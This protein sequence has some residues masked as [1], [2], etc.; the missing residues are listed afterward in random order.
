MCKFQKIT[1]VTFYAAKMTYVNFHT[2]VPIRL[3]TLYLYTVADLRG[4][5]WY[6]PPPTLYNVKQ[7]VIIHNTIKYI[8]FT[9]LLFFR[10]PSPKKIVE[11]STAVY[12]KYYN[13]IYNL[14]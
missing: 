8:I 7:F 5:P 1:I 6:L 9:Y 11:K 4:G 13:I 14:L 2:L 3:T 12:I 10:T